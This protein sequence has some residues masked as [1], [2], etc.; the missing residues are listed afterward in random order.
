MP[1]G[2]KNAGATYQRLVNMT[3]VDLIGKIMEARDHIGH[4]DNTFQILRKYKMKLNPLVVANNASIAQALST[5]VWLEGL[6]KDLR[7][8]SKLAFFQERFVFQ[9]PLFRYVHGFLYTLCFYMCTLK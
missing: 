4:L 1:F 8:K 5:S 9:L 3:F 6:M 7:A 2:L